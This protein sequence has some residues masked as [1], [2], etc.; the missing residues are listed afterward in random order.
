[1]LGR[2][3]RLPCDLIFR[4][5]ESSGMEVTNYVESSQESLLNKHDLARHKINLA[6]DRM[7]AHYDAKANYRQF[8]EGDLL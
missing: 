2:E 4:S 6:S 7:K 8:N 1:M 5:A 3:L